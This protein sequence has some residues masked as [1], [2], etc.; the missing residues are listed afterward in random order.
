MPPSF[1][2]QRGS[3]GVE[4][5]LLWTVQPVSALQELEKDGVYRCDRARSWNLTKKGSLES[6][7]R[8]LTEQMIRRIGYPPTGVEYPVWA[9]HTWEY[10]R[11][12]PEADSAAF[13][14][15]TED[16]VALTLDLPE[17]R[18]VQTDFDAWQHVLAGTYVAHGVTE[19][20]LCEEEQMLDELDEEELEKA[21][22]ESWENVFLINP[23]NTE[24]AQRGRYIQAT[25]WEIRKEDIVQST[26]LPAKKKE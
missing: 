22:K 8:W 9:W 2:G 16:K 13:L 26:I 14:E 25:F 7:Y 5:V 12:A 20:E 4:A 21:V 6:S 17:D 24:T 11:K 18:V 10:E 1:Q 19:G 3:R 15:R 23:V